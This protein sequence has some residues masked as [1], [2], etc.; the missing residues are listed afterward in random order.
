MSIWAD[1]NQNLLPLFLEVKQDP[2]YGKLDRLMKKIF[3]A[4]ILLSLTIITSNAQ[5]FYG[6]A[7]GGMNLSSLTKTTDAATRVRGNFGAFIGFQFGTVFA[8]Q[9][10]A[11]YSFQGAQ[12]N[13]TKVN[14]DYLKIP[15]MAK[16]YLIKGL[17]VEGGVSFN[18]LTSA[19]INGTVNRGMNG[20]DFVV[21]IGVAYQLGRHFEF[22]LRYDISLAQYNPDHSG[23]NSLWSI[24]LAYRF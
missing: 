23:A 7:R 4:F 16:L 12:I 3:F 21:P 14:L 11:L 18:I 8:L 17:N 5:G 10:E 19:L 6:G 15:I 22:G 1:F 13:E 2:H 9:A 24:N 20:F